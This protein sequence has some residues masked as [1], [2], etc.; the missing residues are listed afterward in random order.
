M[1]CNNY[2]LINEYVN[3]L[4]QAENDLNESNT[5]II[6]LQNQ[7]IQL[8]DNQIVPINIDLVNGWNMLGFS[9]NQE[10][11]AEDALVSIVDYIIIFK[12]NSGNVYMPEFSFNGIGDLN[13][14]QGYQ[15]KTNGE[16]VLQY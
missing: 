6:E 13:P 7:V 4:L 5:L 16:C 12:D 3:Y 15:V 1:I 2:N 11:T 9:C 14:G 10:R 8:Q